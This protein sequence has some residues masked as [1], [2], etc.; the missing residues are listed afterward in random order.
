MAALAAAPLAGCGLG[1][2]LRVASPPDFCVD[3]M[4]RAVPEAT[5]DITK[6]TSESEALERVKVEVEAT[7]TDSSPSPMIA[8]EVAVECV[9][10]HDALIDFH[11]TK[12]PFK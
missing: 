8:S 4:R 11:W 10:D 1:S 3:T 6:Q 2:S 7:R 12:S 9:F 5:F